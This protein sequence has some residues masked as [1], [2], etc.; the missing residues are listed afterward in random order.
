MALIRQRQRRRCLILTYF[1][2]HH[3]EHAD[4]AHTSPL[5]V[6]NSSNYE[7]SRS[8]SVSQY[9]A[10]LGVAISSCNGKTFPLTNPHRLRIEKPSTGEGNMKKNIWIGSGLV[11][12]A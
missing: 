10:L 2:S 7:N 3:R 6:D 4:M 11:I 5:G 9:T 8:C 12:A 1:I